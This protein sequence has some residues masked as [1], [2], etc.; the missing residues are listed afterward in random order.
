[1]P[2]A[3][4]IKIHTARGGHIAFV[5]H[6]GIE[7]AVV[8]GGRDGYVQGKFFKRVQGKAAHHFIAKLV[9]GVIVFVKDVDEVRFGH[10]GIGG[11]AAA[12]AGKVIA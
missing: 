8:V 5:G 11:E 6:V 4:I 3:Y 2:H 9:A 1:M 7:V 10:V 12:Y